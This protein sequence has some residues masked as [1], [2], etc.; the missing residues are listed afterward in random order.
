[1]PTE[2]EWE[3]AARGGCPSFTEW[4]YAYSGVDSEEKKSPNKD[5]ALD[6]IAWYYH[7]T[8]SYGS[9]IDNVEDF[10][11]YMKSGNFK[12][13]GLRVH[14]VGQK[15][16]NSLGLYD[17]SGNVCEWCWDGWS[18]TV[19][20]RTSEKGNADS[21]YKTIKGGSWRDVAYWSSVT[22][23]RGFAPDTKEDNIGFRVVL[24]VKYQSPSA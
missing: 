16:A 17:M 9:S 11:N 13:Q 10:F 20:K 4:H 3:F 24:S 18:E 1:M 15:Q 22:A 7:N 23:R 8:I 14:A 12:I 19:T 6:K 21:S 5:S 2:A